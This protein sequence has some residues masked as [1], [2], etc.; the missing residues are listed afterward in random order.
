MFSPALPWQFHI[1]LT[2]KCNAGCPM[3]P[4]TDAMNFCKPDRAKVFNVELTLADIA[5]AFPDEFCRRV[6]RVVFS[7]AYGD[8]IAAS[9]L[10]EIT[11]HL[12]ARGVHV[13]VST[14]GGLRR[15]AW[16]RRF[17][18]AVARTGGRLELHVDGLEDTNRLYRVHTNFRR[19]MENAAAFIA[20]GARAEWHFIMFRHNQHQ[21][22]EARRRAR[23]MGFSAFTVI[24]TI[25]FSNS[26]TYPYRMPDGEARVLEAPTIRAADIPVDGEPFPK[27]PRGPEP[28]VRRLAVNGVSCKSSAFNR[29]YI[30]AHGI[31]SACC[32]V[33]G[34]EDE[35]RL[36]RENGLEEARFD[37]RRRPLEEILADEPFAS[38]YAAGWEADSLPNCRR[39]CGLGMVNAR[40]TL[41]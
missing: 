21:V 11:E 30:S 23:E 36:R 25:R 38:L 3:C 17:G 7:G 5:R 13:A 29:A 16:W 26:P 12:V 40:R 15:P 4:R 28:A 24:D 37:I 6:D 8:P 39:K 14:N 41:D 22:A 32:W 35:A 34:S 20:T 27:R 31:V 33:T 10:L 19:I 18:E 9:Q 1:E 2:D